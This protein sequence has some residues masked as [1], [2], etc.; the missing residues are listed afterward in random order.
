M[1][2]TYI[3]NYIGIYIHLNNY[4]KQDKNHHH[5]KHA[6]KF[7]DHLLEYESTSKHIFFKM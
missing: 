2:Y 1:S 7:Q 3:H 6:T 4:Q 5:L